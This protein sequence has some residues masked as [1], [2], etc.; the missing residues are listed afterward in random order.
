MTVFKAGFM[1]DVFCL[2]LL[3]DCDDIV[4]QFSFLYTLQPIMLCH[5]FIN[6]DN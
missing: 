4:K 2:Y 3:S 1:H 5:S 6:V